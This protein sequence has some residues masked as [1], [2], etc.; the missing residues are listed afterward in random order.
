LI[1]FLPRSRHHRTATTTASTEIPVI[2]RKSIGQSRRKHGAQGTGACR[3]WWLG[4][5]EGRCSPLATG[6]KPGAVNSGEVLPKGV[7]TDDPT[8]AAK[9]MGPESLVNTTA[10]A[11]KIAHKSR[12]LVCPAKQRT[13][14]GGPALAAAI[15]SAIAE[16]SGTSAGPPNTHQ[17]RTRPP[18][19]NRTKAT[20]LSPPAPG[21]VGA[22]RPPLVELRR[23][24]GREAPGW[25]RG[26]RRD[27]SNDGCD[28][29]AVGGPARMPRL[30]VPQYD[31]EPH[32]HS[33]CAC[34]L[35]RGGAELWW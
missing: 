12:R 24:A 7:T 20:T 10:Q 4:P 35:L 34:G 16:A 6:G 19:S 15:C 13:L 27:A 3:N 28:E 1:A 9:C 29:L 11:R 8:A 32:L 2:Q 26:P 23:C 18:H 21:I 25:L 30:G 31:V 22:P 5:S 17:D 14:L 33:V